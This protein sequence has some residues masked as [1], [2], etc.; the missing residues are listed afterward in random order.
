MSDKPKKIG[1]STEKYN[2]DDKFCNCFVCSKTNPDGLHLDVKYAD[3][4]STA[5]YVPKKNTEGLTGLMHGGFSMMLMDEVMYYAVESLGV[6]C[7]ALHTET[8]FAGRAYVGHVLRAEGEVERRD[9]RKFYVKGRLWDTET[10]EDVVKAT[11]LYYEVDMN[12]FL[13]DEE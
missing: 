8:D 12:E 10:G 2:V 7:V 6:D 11:G 3:G 5:D 13:P 9:G 4:K 1:V